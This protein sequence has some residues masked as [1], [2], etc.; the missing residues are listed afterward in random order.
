GFSSRR[1]LIQ[2]LNRFSGSG[3]NLLSR[4]CELEMQKGMRIVG[5]LLNFRFLRTCE[6]IEIV[7]T[8]RD[9]AAPVSSGAEG[10][11]LFFTDLNWFYLVLFELKYPKIELKSVW[12]LH[13]ER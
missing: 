10:V 8:D 7:L 2:L 6:S 1:A 9:E 13:G 3:L 5:R 11:Q 4:L 12:R